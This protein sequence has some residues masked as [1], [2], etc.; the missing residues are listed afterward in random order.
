MATLKKLLV[1]M[2]GGAVLGVV[3]ATFIG[4]SFI[5]WYNEGGSGAQTMLVNPA[6][7]ARSV[8][9][10]MLQAQLFGA[11]AG[12]VLLLVVGVLVHRMKAQKAAGQALPASASGPVAPAPTAASPAK[13]AP[14]PM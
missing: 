14:P 12:A 1:Y 9:H 5:P 11:G 6:V 8:L 3:V 13:P 4:L 2:L 10:S 7:F